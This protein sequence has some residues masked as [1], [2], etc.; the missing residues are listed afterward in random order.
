MTMDQ[1]TPAERLRAAIRAER[2][3]EQAK[4]QARELSAY[5]ARAHLLARQELE[6]ARHECYGVAS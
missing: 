1:T 2:A 3:A 5:T 4:R 6:E